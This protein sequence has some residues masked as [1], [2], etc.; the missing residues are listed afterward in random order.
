MRKGIGERPVRQTIV[1]V[2]NGGGDKTTDS[3]EFTIALPDKFKVGFPITFEVDQWIIMDPFVN[4]RGRTYL[5]NPEAE[6]ISIKVVRKGDKLLLSAPSIQKLVEKKQSTLEL[7]PF[8]KGG[9]VSSLS[10]S[11]PPVSADDSRKFLAY[12]RS[13]MAVRR[14]QHGGQGAGLLNSP[15]LAVIVGTAYSSMIPVNLSDVHAPELN[16][17]PESGPADFLSKEASELGFTVQELEAAINEWTRTAKD[18]YARG[19]SALN[20]KRYPAAIKYFQ[21]SINSSGTNLFEKY[22]FLAKS[23]YSE[24]SYR[25]AEAALKKIAASQSKDPIALN[26]LG[27]V[28][29]AQAKYAEAEPPLVQALAISRQVGDRSMEA[30]TLI[31]IGEV[32]RGLAQYDR[33]LEVYQQ[34]LAISRQVGSRASE[35]T[36][37]N[38]IGEV[39]RNRRQYDQALSSY[40]QGVE[41]SDEGGDLAGEAR[42]LNNIGFV[43]RTLAQYPRAL[44]YYQQ[45]L[46]INREAGDRA[47]EGA[48]LGNMGFVFRALGQYDQSLEAY[49]QA[50]AIS[51]EQ[52]DR[53]SEV[54]LLIFTG[55]VYQLQRQYA[56]AL[57]V[58]QQALPISREVHDR[59]DEGTLLNNLGGLYYMQQ[60]Y[61]P[62]L[63]YFQQALAIYREVGDRSGEAAS[64]NGIGA[65]Y[66]DQG[67][68]AKA[69]E[70]HQRSV[71]I[72]REAGSRKGEAASLTNIGDIYYRQGR[73]AQALESYQQALAV[74]EQI[75]DPHDFELA[76]DADHIAR[77]L[78][79]LGR[80]REAKEF[81]DR[82]AA[83]RSR[84]R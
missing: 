10:G 9:P 19:L 5:P 59:A 14:H 18:P 37:L 11:E 34:A 17:D 75:L 45:A 22:L 77:T 66:Y 12:A 30:R 84:D 62:A 28:L 44:T 68:Y 13:T 6:T 29:L 72:S 48:I 23:E 20:A 83:I 21:E 26:Y 54:E 52:G 35:G 67:Q 70:A 74:N 56:P 76:K 65:I 39:Y 32:Y 8:V 57:G 64:L 71:A 69:L 42:T 49:R 27:V 51:R 38:N 31:N 55:Y 79:A 41:A 80:D 58:Y 46:A 81:K 50:L 16:A 47:A 60:Q 63:E 7:Q 36:I 43:Y 33:A 82:A 61:A 1:R 4:D 53:V 78:R 24:G 73:Y 15:I 2:R 25:D 40:V 3:G